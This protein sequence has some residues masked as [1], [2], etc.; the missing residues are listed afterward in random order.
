V[1]PLLKI[2][3]P[4]AATKRPSKKDKKDKNKP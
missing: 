3:P 4:A 1:E 2:V